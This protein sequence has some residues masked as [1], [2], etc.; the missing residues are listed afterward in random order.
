MSNSDFSKKKQISFNLIFFYLFSL[1]FSFSLFFF[2]F[3][4]LLL[5]SPLSSS[6]FSLQNIS[7]PLPKFRS[8]SPQVELFFLC[9]ALSWM[10][11]DL[12]SQ[13][14]GYIKENS[15]AKVNPFFLSVL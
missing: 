9:L 13:P 6:L 5:L 1:F 2:T 15:F 7:F 11:G 14:E 12:A 8:L 4:L 10:I 3:I